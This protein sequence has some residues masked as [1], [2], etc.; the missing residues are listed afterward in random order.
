MIDP[1]CERGKKCIYFKKVIE[2]YH[3]KLHPR[4]DKI[5]TGKQ[6]SYYCENPRRIKSYEIARRLNHEEK[7]KD[8][9]FKVTNK[10]G[11]FINDKSKK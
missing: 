10:L 1:I 6:V 2:D 8:C 11:D 3:Y 9:G 4:S 7:F 5:F